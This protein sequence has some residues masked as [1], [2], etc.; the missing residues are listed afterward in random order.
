[1]PEARWASY[2]LFPYEQVLGERELRTLTGGD[3]ERSARGFRFEGDSEP[4]V[5]RSTY[6]TS[7][8]E[9]DGLPATT[10]QSAVERIHWELRG[11]DGSRQATR[12][13]L[14]GVHEYKGKFNPQVV[15]AL[16]NV[17]DRDADVLVDPFCGSGTSLIEGLRLGMD[18]VGVDRSPVAGLLA[19]AKVRALTSRQSTRLRREFRGLVRDLTPTMKE[20]QQAGQVPDLCEVL[21]SENVDYLHDWFTREA[22]APVAE[23]V[24]HLLAGRRTAANLLA[25]VALSS[26]LRPVSLQ[27]PEDLRVRRRPEPFD[28][29]PVWELFVEACDRIDLGLDEIELWPNT[30]CTARVTVGSADDAGTFGD[31]S[32]H[33]RRLFLMSPPYATALPY[34][35]T[36]RL[37]IVALGLGSVG[38]VRDLERE[39]VGSREWRKV[40]EKE[41][42]GRLEE[43]V[44]ELPA[45]VVELVADIRERN[46]AGGAGFRRAAVPALLYRYFARMRRCFEA[47]TPHLRRGERAVLIVGYNRTTAD[48]EEIVIPTPALLGEIA[49]TVGYHVTE[50]ISLETW[51][52]YGMHSRNGVN[53]EDALVLERT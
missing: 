26:I 1:M 39:L 20:A 9:A 40:H 11:G 15:R 52:R 13:G 18:V 49:A 47:W 16:C 27:L 30:E 7:V 19:E 51:P 38:Q 22:L 24:K 50:I 8:I 12:F 23:A 17:I 28:A 33:S 36:D 46:A 34:I 43:N 35:D 37:S 14:H 3:L 32:M 45:S 10:S 41:W 5:E 42:W 48:G 31:L 53:G 6:F 21:P 29:P 25:Q 44:D 2:R 4:V